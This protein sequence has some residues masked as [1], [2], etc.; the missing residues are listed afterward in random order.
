MASAFSKEG[1]T[2]F[3]QKVLKTL[4]K[5]VLWRW[6][7]V[8]YIVCCCRRPELVQN[9][10][11]SMA[12]IN[13]PESRSLET[14]IPEGHLALLQINTLSLKLEPICNAVSKTNSNMLNTVF[15]GEGRSGISAGLR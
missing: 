8:K 14:A 4:D 11:L 2:H 7:E 3:F 6:S 9:H 1:L 15:D 10:S 13:S 5:E 12:P